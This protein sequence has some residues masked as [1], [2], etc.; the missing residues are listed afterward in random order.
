M[1][2]SKT[3]D[4]IVCHEGNIDPFFNKK[5]IQRRCKNNRKKNEKENNCAKNLNCKF[6][7]EMASWAQ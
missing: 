7:S 3:R 5:K 6:A 1:V 2:T 4:W